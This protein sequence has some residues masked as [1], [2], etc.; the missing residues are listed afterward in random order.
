MIVCWSVKGGSGTT[1]VAST[2]ALVHAEKSPRGAVIVD[3]AGDVPAVLGLAE[4]NGIGVAEWFTQ[5]EN[6]SRMTLQSIAIQATANL[7]LISRGAGQFD[8]SANFAELCASLA[9]FDLPVIVDAGCGLP[10]TDLIA[11]ASSSLLITRPCYLALRRAAQLNV[12][13]TG[14]VLVNEP[15]RA[16]GKRDVESVIGAPVIA[17]ITFDATISRAVDAGLLASRLPNMLAKQ[18][19]VAA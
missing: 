3:L 18:L 13:P 15:G 17:E 6:S 8:S 2:L 7:Q 1:V 4:P 11:R 9:T 16:L 10:S 5:N 12:A 19:S 14:V